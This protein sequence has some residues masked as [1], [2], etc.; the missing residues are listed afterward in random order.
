VFR[1]A[2]LYFALLLLF[3]ILIVG[4]SLAGKY[5]PSSITDMLSSTNLVQPTNL[6]NNDTIGATET[7][8]GAADYTGALQTMSASAS[9]TAAAA[10]KIRLF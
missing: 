1:Y 2:V 8:T 9:A 5:V 3:L 4:P 6:D 7:G 10:A